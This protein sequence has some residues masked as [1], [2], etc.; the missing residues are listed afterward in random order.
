MGVQAWAQPPFPHGCESILRCKKLAKLA[1]ELNAKSGNTPFWMPAQMKPKSILEEYAL[2]VFWF[3]VKRLGWTAEA[4]AR[5]GSAAGAEFWVQR[6]V[7]SQPLA[8]RGVNWHFD[9]DE[10]MLDDSGLCVHPF[11]ATATYLTGKG[12]PLVVLT[13][14]TLRTGADGAPEP[15]EPDLGKGGTEHYAFVAFPSRGLHIAF[16]GNLLHGVPPLLESRKGERL[17]LLLNVWLR[18]RPLSMHRCLVGVDRP[19]L[20]AGQSR[21]VGRFRHAVFAGRQLRL[22]RRRS[23]STTVESTFDNSIS[24]TP[25]VGSW[26]LTGLWLPRNLSPEGVWRVQQKTSAL[27]LYSA[28]KRKQNRKR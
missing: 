18:H 3:H 4:V 7:A 22:R 19:K 12:A 2:D 27:T 28:K 6:R 16:R 9:K 17:A 10:N 25:D 20:C 11:V 8:M 14:P 24:L 23:S 5:L 21:H 15:E 1:R 13:R 26:G